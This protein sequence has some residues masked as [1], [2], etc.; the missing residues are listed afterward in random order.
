MQGQLNSLTKEFTSTA[1]SAQRALRS[2][3]GGSRKKGSAP[4]PDSVPTAQLR[5]GYGS[6]SVQLPTRGSGQEKVG[7]RSIPVKAAA[8]KE[9]AG[10]A[11]RP[12][13]SQRR[14]TCFHMPQIFLQ[15]TVS[16]TVPAPS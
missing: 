9:T 6:T 3:F 7:R 15:C 4:I 1:S 10:A 13:F 16:L 5:P 14:I 12:L 11:M 2:L 8:P